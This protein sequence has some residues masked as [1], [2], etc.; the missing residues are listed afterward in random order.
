MHE[1]SL[2][3]DLMRHIDEV[4]TAEGARRIVA[5]SVW[6]GALTDMSAGHFIEH[7]EHAAAGTRAAGARV[8][9]TVSTD[10]HD[11]RA[12]HVL[13]QGVEVEV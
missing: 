5:V 12:Q 1:T 11:A 3:K 6:V 9:V 2:M 4:A 8:D 10:L 7:F 13:L